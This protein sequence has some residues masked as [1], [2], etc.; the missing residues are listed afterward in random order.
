MGSVKSVMAWI[1]YAV[2]TTL[3]ATSLTALTNLIF[4]RDDSRTLLK[5][6]MAIF[7]RARKGK[8]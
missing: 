3:I 6:L 5:K 2:L 1:S 8:A 7:R 4:Y